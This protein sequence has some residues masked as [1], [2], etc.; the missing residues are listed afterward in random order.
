MD[1]TGFDNVVLRLA[2]SRYTGTSRTHYESDLRLFFTW[3]AERELAPL[4]LGRAQ[5]ELYVRWMQEIRRF[6][7]STVSR[8]M[9]VVTG[10]YR[11]CVIDAVLA[12]SP[13]EY[14][15]RPRVP[16]ESPVPRPQEPRPAP[17]LHPRRLHGLRHLNKPPSRTPAHAEE[18]AGTD[19]ARMWRTWLTA[20]TA[21]P[22]GQAQQVP[23][24]TG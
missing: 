16:N 23:F 7:P 5:V 1:V 12:H 24:C 19:A 21:V 8:R 20:D 9:A 15:R 14:V 17:Q 2:A 22:Q 13:A 3:C 6:K 18:S 11:T 10:F 4:T